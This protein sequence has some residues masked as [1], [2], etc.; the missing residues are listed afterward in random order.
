MLV[1]NVLREL[2]AS[3]RRYRRLRR[4]N[5]DEGIFETQGQVGRKEISSSSVSSVG[6]LNESFKRMLERDPR[7]AVGSATHLVQ[8]YIIIESRTSHSAISINGSYV[9]DIILKKLTFAARKASKYVQR[10][11]LKRS[12][13]AAESSH[14]ADQLETTRAALK[15]E[16]QR[17]KKLEESL[18]RL[19]RRSSR[20]LSTPS[21]PGSSAEIISPHYVLIAYAEE[22]SQRTAVQLD[23]E[24]KDYLIEKMRKS[25]V[26]GDSAPVEGWL[27][28]SPSC[29]LH[30][31]W[32]EKYVAL[33]S[34]KLLF[35][36]SSEDFVRQRP[37]RVIQLD[38]IITVRNVQ[39]DMYGAFRATSNDQRCIQV[40]YAA[41][42]ETKAIHIFEKTRDSEKLL[43]S[44]FDYKQKQKS[45]RILYIRTKTYRDK[46]Q[47]LKRLKTRLATCPY[48]GSACMVGGALLHCLH[49]LKEFSGAGD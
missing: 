35:F 14:L 45:S 21:E 17:R 33:S 15:E 49:N 4:T 44:F 28:V 16:R 40:S 19:Q 9:L 39:T 41:E 32:R 37:S 23:L 22:V 7:Q 48:T 47:W 42:G 3:S 46:Q 25:H 8:D 43:R 18:R 31:V 20:V 26:S 12:S 13:E 11:T 1:M 5:L 6:T 27:E 36:D 2:T 24:G 29:G 38:K 34:R 30:E 10:A